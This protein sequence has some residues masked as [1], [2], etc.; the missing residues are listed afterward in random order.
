MC[1]MPRAILLERVPNED[2]DDGG[3]EVDV[4]CR[5]IPSDDV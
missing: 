4:H 1:G 5:L 2:V 3:S